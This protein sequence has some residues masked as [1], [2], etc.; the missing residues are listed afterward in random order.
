[1]LTRVEARTV[2]T[3]RLENGMGALM[4]PHMGGLFHIRHCLKLLSSREIGYVPFL[5]LTVQ[6]VRQWT[7]LG[8]AVD[9]GS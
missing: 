1:M 3:S 4:S 6:S 5:V 9:V 8:E 2:R 7:E